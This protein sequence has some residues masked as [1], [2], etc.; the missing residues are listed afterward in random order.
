MCEYVPVNLHQAL[1]HMVSS[2]ALY[3]NKPF[4][5][6]IDRPPIISFIIE[7]MGFATGKSWEEAMEV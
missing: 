5:P 2:G 6:T 1:A 4:F 3:F 7:F